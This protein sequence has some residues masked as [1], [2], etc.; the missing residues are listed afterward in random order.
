MSTLML[1]LRNVIAKDVPARVRQFLD[2]VAINRTF[3]DIEGEDIFM[4]ASTY[5]FLLGVQQDANIRME[6]LTFQ[7]GDGDVVGVLH[8]YIV[9][10]NIFVVARSRDDE[11]VPE[12]SM[13]YR[14]W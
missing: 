12:L 4:P 2:D 1:N 5:A 13:R 7:K 3:T 8:N 9:R 10:S 14:S 6:E 11:N